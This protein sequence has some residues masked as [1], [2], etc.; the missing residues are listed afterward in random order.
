MFSIRAKSLLVFSL[1]VVAVGGACLAT[2]AMAEGPSF[3]CDKV[4]AGSVEEMICR[5]SDLSKLDRTLSDVYEAASQKAK[6]EHPPVLKAEQRGW[7]K[8]RDECWKSNDTR[9][10]AEEEYRRRIAELQARYRLVPGRG[11]VTYACDGN[12]ANQV[13]VTFFETAPPTMIAERGDSVSLMYLQPGAS[14]AKY[15]GRN[16]TFWEKAGEA[17][18]TWG[19]GAPEMRCRKTQ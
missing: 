19:Y 17:L 7:I 3:S 5:D 2:A 1:A 13:V 10:C 14:G 11:P 6:N 12:A 8:G 16:E 4:E 9:K 15:Q 18:V